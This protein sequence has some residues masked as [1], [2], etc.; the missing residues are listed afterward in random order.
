[1]QEVKILIAEDDDQ[2][3]LVVK[4]AFEK[5]ELKDFVHRVND[6]EELIKYLKSS[7]PPKF[8]LLDLNM[9]KIDGRVAL[10]EIRQDN[11]LKEIP[12]IV[13]TTSEAKEDIH[14]SY[15]LGANSFIK[16]PTDFNKLV[17]IVRSISNYWLQVVE[18]PKEN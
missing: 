8:I 7:K 4:K 11:D 17:E 14:I 10:R 1:M 12:I 2:D 5:I 13:F 3:Y 15:N 16:K 9:P 18:L 6:G